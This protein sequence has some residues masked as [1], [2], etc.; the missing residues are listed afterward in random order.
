M[1]QLELP[2]E[3]EGILELEDIFEV[4]EPQARL[5]LLAIARRLHA[6]QKEYGVMD[7]FD[8]KRDYFDEAAEESLDFVVYHAM[9]K[10]KMGGA[11]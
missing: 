10:L 2:L 4:L 3:M 8:G 11:K 9:H 5:V 7:V 1:R 6:G